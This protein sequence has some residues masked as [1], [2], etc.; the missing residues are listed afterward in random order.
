ME[1]FAW[2]TE[3][4]NLEDGDVLPKKQGMVD[5]H[6]HLDRWAAYVGRDARSPL[7][8]M[9][10][11]TVTSYCFQKSWRDSKKQCWWRSSKG[12]LKQAFGLQPVEAD[13]GFTRQTR[14]E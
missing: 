9:D 8:G 11:D 2:R 13:S 10:Y 1:S 4:R 7:E 3:K 12:T 6:Y 14:D 5:G